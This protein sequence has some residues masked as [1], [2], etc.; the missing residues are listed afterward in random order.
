MTTDTTAARSVARARDERSLSALDRAIRD[1]REVEALVPFV[2]LLRDPQARRPWREV[3]L[4]PYRRA[5]LDAEARAELAERTE[6][7][8]GEHR[9][10]A[11]ADVLDVLSGV[12]WR[13]E[14]LAA[15][16]LPAAWCPVL[17]PA[18]PAA[19]P[20]PYLRAA[21]EHLPAAV[22]AWSNGK[23]FA[24]FAADRA[25]AILAEVE[26][27]LALVEDGH[28]VKALCPWC[29]GGLTGAYTWRVRIVP[30]GEP[31]IC[32]ESGLCDPPSRD[33]TTWWAGTP[34]WPLRDWP[35]LARRLQ[36]LD[37]RRATLAAPPVPYDRAQGAT[38]RAG[39]PLVPEAEAAALRGAAP[40]EALDAWITDRT[41]PEGTAA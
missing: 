27:A 17:P 39:A 40:D 19:D 11:R 4:D 21:A 16:V 29:R 12:L 28:V 15:Y 14:D 9:D 24:Y 35:W 6:E 30:G 25:A 41:D 10:A 7:A 34:V 18:G 38:G 36:H 22:T 23:T 33:V 26:Q 2:A 8:P 3:A 20:R 32:C 13:A 31:A 5:E 37:R 1:L